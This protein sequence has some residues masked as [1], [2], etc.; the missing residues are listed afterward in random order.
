MESTYLNIQKALSL[1][2]LLGNSVTLAVK[3]LGLA[4]R[5]KILKQYLPFE[6]I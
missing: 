2:A 6:G 1:R 4:V 5:E 3:L